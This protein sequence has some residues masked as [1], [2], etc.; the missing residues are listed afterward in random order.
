ME[1]EYLTSGCWFNM[2]A[3]NRYAYITIAI[4]SNLQ[5]QSTLMLWK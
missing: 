4:A 2:S 1:L 3:S 5:I